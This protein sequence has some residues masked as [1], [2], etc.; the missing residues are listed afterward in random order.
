MTDRTRVDRKM[1]VDGAN[2]SQISESKVDYDTNISEKHKNT[3]KGGRGR[4]LDDL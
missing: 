2:S 3:T 1:K 4:R